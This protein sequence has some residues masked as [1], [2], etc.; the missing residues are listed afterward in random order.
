MG[1]EVR[2]ITSLHMVDRISEVNIPFA[3]NIFG[4]VNHSSW[5]SRVKNFNTE[6]WNYQ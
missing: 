3:L 5:A 1:Y 6:M 4:Y 2:E